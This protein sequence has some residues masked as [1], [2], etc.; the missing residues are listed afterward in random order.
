[1]NTTL[2]INVIKSSL[3]IRIQSML[4]DTN[5]RNL[6]DLHN[7]LKDK[8]LHCLVSEQQRYLG[9]NDYFAVMVCQVFIDNL[10]E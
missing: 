9:E 6:I 5:G 2:P 4:K 8:D 10:S 7:K 1:M 3:N